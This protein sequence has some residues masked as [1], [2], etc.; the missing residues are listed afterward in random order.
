MA[1]KGN[2][3]M[4]PLPVG[5]IRPDGWLMKEIVL[6]NGLQKR[7]GLVP[8]LLDNGVWAGGEILP[9]YVRG[10]ILLAGVLGDKTLS[11]KAESFLETMYAGAKE[12]GDFG[13]NEKIFPAAKIEGLKAVLSYYELTGDEK[14]IAFLRK[15][16]KNQFNTFSVT[17]YFYNARARLLEEIP[18]IAAVFKETDS[19]WLHDLGEKLR[20][21]SNDWFRLAANF[22]YKHPSHRYVS[23][24]ALKKL[25][26]TILSYVSIGGAEPQKILTVDKANGEWKKSTHQ[27][28]V[29]LNGVN[30]A[31]AIK[32]PCTWG[33]FLGDTALKDHSL[34]LISALEKY[35][36]NGTGMFGA[37]FYL[38]GSSPTRGMDVECAVETL[39]SLVEVLGETGNNHVADLIERIAFNILPA[40]YDG[41]GAVQDVIMANQVEASYERKDLFRESEFGNAYVAGHLTRGA[42][43]LLGA[44]PTFLRSVCFVRDNELNFKCYAPCIIDTSVGGNHIRIKEETGYPFR[45]TIVFKVESA[46]G[47]PEI[48]INFRVP[49]GTSMQLV[50]G[51]QVVASSTSEISV[52]CILKTGSTFMLKLDIPLL[53]KEN[54]DKSLTMMK[55]NVVMAS[56]LAEEIKPTPGMDGVMNVTFLKKWTFAPIVSK[57]VVGGTRR[58]FDGEETIVN[59]VG[60]NP[61]SHQNP[62]FELRIR[63]KNVTSWDYNVDGVASIPKKLEFS[64]DSMTRVYVPFGCTGIRICQFPPC[65]KS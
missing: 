5:A 45:N 60:D 34:K 16:F 26:K 65:F 63:S 52:K 15:Y 13:P 61:F 43:S 9:K 50:S 21:T 53:V 35:H 39:E 27:K 12:G 44:Y 42:I 36:G 22:K 1:K 51:G 11:E 47:D 14:A 6:V 25:K 3:A 37:D 10:I 24:I 46:E 40:A 17:P 2:P 57:R 8:G 64:E 58:V 59:D 41:V 28:T 23:N 48:K 49:N 31:K 20:E 55:G 56:K 54:K 62:P 29:E 33:K 38:A 7:L 30:V 4:T 32:Y 19:E 18:A